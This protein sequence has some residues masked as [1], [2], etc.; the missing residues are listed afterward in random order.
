MYL[1][2]KKL[3]TNSLHIQHLDKN[4]SANIETIMK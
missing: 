3:L 4:W 1:Y 2:E